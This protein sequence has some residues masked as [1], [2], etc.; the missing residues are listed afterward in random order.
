MAK[1]IVTYFD[2]PG[3]RGEEV[4]LALTLAGMDFEDNRVDRETFAKIK[5]DMPF[6]TMPTLEID[7]R[8]VFAQS[9]AILR[10]IGREHGLYPEDAFEAAR[11][12]ALME[13]AEDLRHRIAATMRLRDPAEKLAVRQQLAAEYLPQWG[14]SIERLIGEG[15]F[16][17]GARPG[18][19]DIKLYMIDR[20]ISGGG[21][22]DIP[23]D[24]F[25]GFPRLKALA[26]AF[27]EHPAVV[28]W[29]GASA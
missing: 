26:A 14:R 9:N 29:Y 20:W 23:V 2:F 5:P 13:A 17:G 8:G 27:S 22:D 12:D 24:L 3:S 16:A 7:G 28:A 6:G 4:R 25:D 21:V 11:H 18:V 15:P 19:A 10:L 1:P